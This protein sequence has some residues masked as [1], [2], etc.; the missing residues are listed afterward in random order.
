MWINKGKCFI[1]ID[2]GA[3]HQIVDSLREREKDFL[4]SEEAKH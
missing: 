3:Y 1:F 2:R 4:K